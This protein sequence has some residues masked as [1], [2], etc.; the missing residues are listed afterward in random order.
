MVAIVHSA[1]LVLVRLS[2]NNVLNR[3]IN[4]V[5]L[6]LNK[7]VEGSVKVHSFSGLLELFLFLIFIECLE[8]MINR[9]NLM[10]SLR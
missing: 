3:I 4:S 5:S 9:L 2:G 6:Y 10:Q 8:T 7:Y 1:L